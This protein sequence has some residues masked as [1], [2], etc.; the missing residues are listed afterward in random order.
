V[1]DSVMTNSQLLS[2]DANIT[3]NVKEVRFLGEV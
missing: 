2:Y 1:K 3:S